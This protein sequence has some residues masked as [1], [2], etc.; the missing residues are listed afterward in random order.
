MKAQFILHFVLVV[1]IYL[2]WLKMDFGELFL[3]R[4]NYTVI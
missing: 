4:Q 3:R 1:V 2:T